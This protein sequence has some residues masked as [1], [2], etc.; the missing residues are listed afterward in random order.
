MLRTIV[1]GL[2]KVD[3]Q[4]E[5]PPTS[6]FEQLAN[7]MYASCSLDPSLELSFSQML[8]FCLNNATTAQFLDYWNYSVKQNRIPS[9]AEL[10]SDPEFPPSRASLF[11]DVSRSPL[12]WPAIRWKRIRDLYDNPILFADTPPDPTSVKLGPIRDGTV[13][14]TLGMLS[15]RWNTLQRCFLKTGQEHLDRFCVKLYLKGHWTPVYVDTFIPVNVISNRPVFCHSREPNEYWMML[16]EKSLAKALGCY[17]ALID[18]PQSKLLHLLTGSLTMHPELSDLG[19]L[20]LLRLN[21]LLACSFKRS[22]RRYCILKADATIVLTNPFEQNNTLTMLYDEF[23]SD[24]AR[25]HYCP[26]EFGWQSYKFNFKWSGN[27]GGSI[28]HST[29]VMNPQLGFE[30]TSEQTEILIICDLTTSNSDVIGLMLSEHGWEEDTSPGRMSSCVKIIQCTKHFHQEYVW[31]HCTLDPGQYMVVPM[32]YRPDLPPSAAVLTFKVQNPACRP[33]F[34]PPLV[35]ETH[36]DKSPEVFQVFEQ[37]E[38]QEEQIETYQV[39]LK[40]QYQTLHELETRAIQL[41]K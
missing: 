7:E 1:Y 14:A 24:L 11:W 13:A 31:M 12:G 5:A 26:L 19:Q 8:Q 27:G 36:G 30:I 21:G 18:L 20:N 25:L 32:R 16:M 3:R 6:E 29:W 23:V 10:F 17:Q 28:N 34:L 35:K 9:R 39:G 41:R 37:K 33:V 22:D 4:I 40:L 38:R 2:A 15:T